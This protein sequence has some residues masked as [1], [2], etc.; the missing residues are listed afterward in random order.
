M[1][2]YRSTFVVEGYHES[3]GR[4]MVSHQQRPWVLG[5]ENARTRYIGL[6]TNSDGKRA[7]R[8]LQNLDT[9]AV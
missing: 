3:Q 8:V 4:S 2:P 6:N 7:R 5:C 1:I 9:C